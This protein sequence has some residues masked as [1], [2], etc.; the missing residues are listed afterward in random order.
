MLGNVSY[1]KLL[2][3]NTLKTIYFSSIYPH[4]L[5]SISSWGSVP[6]SRMNHLMM[7]QKRAIRIISNVNAREHTTNLFYKLH[8]LK[9][10]EIYKLRLIIIMYKINKGTWIGNLNLTKVDSI[11]NY[12]TRLSVNQNFSLPAIRTNLGKNHL[13]LWDPK[14]GP[15][16]QMKSK[17]CHQIYLKKL[18]LN[19]CLKHTKTEMIE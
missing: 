10:P 15:I 3:K 8:L 2:S 7:L 14:H 9:L 11:H 12:K 16:F 18:Y 1:K 13:V 5:Y 4:L 17:F 19:L 6:L